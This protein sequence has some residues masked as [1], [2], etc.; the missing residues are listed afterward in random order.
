VTGALELELTRFGG[1]SHAFAGGVFHGQD[2][3]SIRAGVPAPDG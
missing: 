1:H 3:C 2:A